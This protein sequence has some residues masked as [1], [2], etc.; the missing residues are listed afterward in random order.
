MATGLTNNCCTPQKLSINNNTGYLSISGG[1]QV[2][3]G[4]LIKSLGIKTPVVDFRLDGY[5]LVITYTDSNGVIQ[6]K[7]VDL[8]GLIVGGSFTVNDTSS[9]DLTY[10]N[11]NL[12]ADIKISGQTG[13]SIQVNADGIWSPIF[14]ETSLNFTDSSTVDFTATGPFNHNITA[15][16]KISNSVAN[17]LQVTNGLF[18][19]D[20]TTYILPGNNISFG[21]GNGSAA[22]PYIISAGGFTQTPLSVN[23]SSSIH[24]NSSGS[25]GMTLTGNVKVSSLLGNALIANADGLYVPQAS[26]NSYS[27]VQ[28]RAA[29][30]GTAPIIYNNVTG[31]IGISLASASSSGY[32]SQTDWNSFNTRIQSGNNLGSTNAFPIYQSQNGTQLNFNG[33]RAGTNVTITQSGGDLIINSSGSGGST[34]SSVFTID[35]IVGDGGALTPTAGSSQFNPTGNPLIGKTILGVWVEGVKIAGVARTNGALYYTFT[36]SSGLLTLTNDVFTADTYYSIMYK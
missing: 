36:P 8:S 23:D 13:N 27:D 11:A 17:K 28:A 22:N 6:N 24:F 14:S 34:S 12:S 26:T 32:L 35:F 1:N 29:I 30:S 33:I 18:V 3:L 25:Y 15:S 4:T 31:V 21:S 19:P 16:V 20:M 10:N 5:I 7:Q 2:Y 9:I